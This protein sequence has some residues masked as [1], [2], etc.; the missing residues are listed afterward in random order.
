M[1]LADWEAFGEKNK[2]FP[3]VQP[4]TWADWEAFQAWR[5]KPPDGIPAFILGPAQARSR[6]ERESAGKMDEVSAA[7]FYPPYVRK[8]EWTKFQNPPAPNDGAVMTYRGINAHK[9]KKA[10]KS[11]EKAFVYGVSQ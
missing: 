11:A 4:K 8:G 9:Y 1:P 3:L 10:Q 7:K 2:P 5:Q 6:A